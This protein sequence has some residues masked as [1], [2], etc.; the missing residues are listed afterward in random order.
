MQGGTE[1]LIDAMG[2]RAATLASLPHVRN[3]LAQVVADLRLTVLA[4]LDH[5]FEAP[6]GITAMRL[7]AESHLALH[8]FPESGVCTLNLYCCSP[9]PAYDWRFV[10]EH[11]LGASAVAVRHV[12]RGYAPDRISE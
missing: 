6:P 1:W 7:L 9:R 4:E 10:L 5:Q 8:T 3:L 2:C 11:H 12:E